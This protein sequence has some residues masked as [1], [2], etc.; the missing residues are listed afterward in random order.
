MHAAEAYNAAQVNGTRV[1]IAGLAAQF[2]VSE[3]TLSRH[4]K[5]GHTLGDFNALKQCLTPAEE[6]TLVK[7][8]LGCANRGLPS[9]HAQLASFANN[10]LKQC[11]GSNAVPVGKNW[12][13][14]FVKRHHETLSTHWTCPL[15]SKHAWALRPDVVEHWFGLVKELIHDKGIKAENVYGMDESGF[16]PGNMG[17]Q[18]VIGHRGAKGQHHQGG[19]DKENVTAVVT[20]CADGTALPP[21][22]VFKAKNIQSHWNST[23]VTGISYVILLF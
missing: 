4:I 3:S 9:T 11:L 13:D 18:K 10:N 22:I 12:T 7:F 1:S 8:V 21:T 16:L 6:T 20:I 5:G 23:G 19:A 15:N 2:H 14:R 17:R